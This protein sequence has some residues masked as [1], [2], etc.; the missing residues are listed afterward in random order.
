MI[1]LSIPC[2]RH[3]EAGVADPQLVE[4]LN[5]TQQ[6]VDVPLAAHLGSLSA[7]NEQLWVTWKDEAS[8]AKWSRVIDRNWRALGQTGP[9]IHL[10]PADETYDYQDDVMNNADGD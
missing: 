4:L 1:S 7:L 10:V 9:T 3:G 5:A 8:R 2:T 6:C